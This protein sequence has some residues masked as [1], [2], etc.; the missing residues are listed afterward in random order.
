MI[1]GKEFNETNKSVLVK[2]TNE[3]CVHNDYLYQEGLN[4]LYSPFQEDI[5]RSND[6][7]YIYGDI[8]YGP[9]LYFCKY[10]DMF[11][12]LYYSGQSMRYIWL[13]TIP[14]D[15]KV[16]ILNKKIKCNKFI[17]T[18]QTDLL[19]GKKIS[20]I[21]FNDTLHD[22][23]KLQYVNMGYY[24]NSKLDMPD[25]VTSITFGEYY[26]QY[27]IF[28]ENLQKLFLGYWFN[29]T[30]KFPCA[31]THLK[32]NDT[33]DK[34]LSLPDSVRYLVLSDDY[35]HD[36]EFPYVT[37][38]VLGYEYNKQIKLSENIQCLVLGI[39]FSHKLTFPINMKE[40]IIHKKYRT[41]YRIPKNI[42]MWFYDNYDEYL[43]YV[44]QIIKN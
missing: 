21:E 10:E 5:Y 33:Y 28:P 29:K 7:D 42:K 11:H 23:D 1:L 15:A 8:Y 30:M 31:L 3:C 13:I 16:I 39:D 18:N 6:N 22:D 12:W 24:L 2:L 27:T 41:M 43:K 14:D 17:M 32:L 19:Q 40:L 26:N 36:V 4:E 9:G 37:H 34:K 38:M 44:D 20:I 25:S 35:S